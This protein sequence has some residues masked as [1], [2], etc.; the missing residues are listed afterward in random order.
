MTEAE[1]QLF[2]AMYESITTL[3]SEVVKLKKTSFE[4]AKR[5]DRLEQLNRGP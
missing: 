4:S 2:D 3:Q 1:R 5:I